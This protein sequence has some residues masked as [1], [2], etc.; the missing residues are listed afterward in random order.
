MLGILYIPVFL[1]F[2]PMLRASGSGVFLI[3]YVL[4]CGWGTDVFAYLGG[5]IFNTRKH[6]FSKVSP[7][8]SIEGC[9][10]GAIRSSNNFYNLYYY[11]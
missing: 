7:N 9:I 10:F 2:L 3:W 5:K 1:M 8:K 11:M 6:K 4:I